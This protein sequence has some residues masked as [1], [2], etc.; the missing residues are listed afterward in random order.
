MYC[1]LLVVILVNIFNLNLLEKF[2]FFI[3]ERIFLISE[4]G[5]YRFAL[6]ADLIFST[7]AEV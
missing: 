4:M 5:F 1:R 6:S 2:F 7:Y 3:L